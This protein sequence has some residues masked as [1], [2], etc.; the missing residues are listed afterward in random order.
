MGRATV[1]E[2][3]I[4]FRCGD[5]RAQARQVEAEQIAALAAEASAC[6][7][8]MMTVLSEPNS[9]GASWM[10][11]HQGDLFRRG[12][13]NVGRQIALPGAAR[14][15]RVA[16]ARLERDGQPHLRDRLGEVAGNVGGER[17]QRRDIEG[18]DR[19]RRGLAAHWGST[20]LGRKPA[21]VLPPP[22]GAMS[23]VSRPAR[24]S[25]SKAS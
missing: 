18:V 11:Q 23:S 21:K 20:R 3:P 19:A 10:R 2:R 22:V 12:E 15:R 8:S 24:A 9:A 25:S 16:G 4:A 7:S 6:N 5:K 14:S 1:A 17:L 13:E